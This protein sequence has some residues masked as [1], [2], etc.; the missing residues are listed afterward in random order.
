[1]KNGSI[2]HQC[3][4]SP[5]KPFAEMNP[6]S[7]A[8]IIYIFKKKKTF[9]GVL[10]LVSEQSC[11]LINKIGKKSSFEILLLKTL[12]TH[13]HTRMYNEFGKYLQIQVAE[14]N[15]KRLQSLIWYYKTLQRF[16]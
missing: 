10:F 2:S 12:Y 11:V 7:K 9:A 6:S 14:H 4:H 1:M 13:T 16:G 15:L 3:S 5:P 8:P